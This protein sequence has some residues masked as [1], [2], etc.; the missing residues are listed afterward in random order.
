[1]S[2]PSAKNKEEFKK[3]KNVLTQ[4]IRKATARYFEKLFVEARGDQ[5]HTWRLINSLL[6][7]S[8]KSSFPNEMLRGDGTFSSDEQEIL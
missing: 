8:Q 6:G 2:F 7:R 3:Y 4:L 1:M 5:K